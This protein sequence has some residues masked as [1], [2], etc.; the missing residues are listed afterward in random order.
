M[1][2]DS[3]G[4]NNYDAF[5]LSLAR[6]MEVTSEIDQKIKYHAEILC[7]ADSKHG[8]KKSSRLAISTLTAKMRD[9]IH[10]LAQNGQFK[11]AF[12]ASL[13]LQGAV[14]VYRLRGYYNDP[15]N[16]PMNV[17][18][19]YRM[20][21]VFKHFCKEFELEASDLNRL[22]GDSNLSITIESPIEGVNDSVVL[23][24]GL[25][26]HLDLK[27]KYRLASVSK[28]FNLNVNEELE[29][30]WRLLIRHPELGRIACQVQ[31]D[32][33]LTNK[34]RLFESLLKESVPLSERDRVQM[35]SSI[36]SYLEVLN[37][38]KDVNLEIFCKHIF[39]EAKDYNADQCRNFL[40]DP[41]N[42]VGIVFL[43]NHRFPVWFLPRVAVIPLYPNDLFE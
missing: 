43:W 11:E 36:E 40:S 21:G 4:Q 18:L 9:H 33:P 5:S 19:D 34:L 37:F 30:F 32:Q 16:P 42:L 38:A 15:L 39:D 6:E 7:S 8:V 26:G 2:I 10:R 3:A 23:L 29:R 31:Q 22:E 28:L 13:M 24:A 35:R 12:R 41:K 20:G 25:L 14:E 27:D 1:Y 17:R